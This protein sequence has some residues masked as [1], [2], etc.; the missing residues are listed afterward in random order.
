MFVDSKVEKTYKV[1]GLL[2]IVCIMLKYVSTDANDLRIAE[3]LIEGSSDTKVDAYYLFRD[4]CLEPIKEAI[5]TFII[6]DTAISDKKKEK[7]ESNKQTEGKDECERETETV[8][9][10]EWADLFADNVE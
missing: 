10:H 8:D 1:F 6:F 5:L 3:L 2:Y 4:A 7:K 9:V